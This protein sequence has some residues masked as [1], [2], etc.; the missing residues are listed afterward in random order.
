MGCCPGKL[1]SAVLEDKTL[2]P[3]LLDPPPRVQ[4]PFPMAG[5]SSVLILCPD[6]FQRD[7]KRSWTML[8]YL[9]FYFFNLELEVMH[10][11][12]SLFQKAAH[13]LNEV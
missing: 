2:L 9:F 10:S 13:S 8:G 6:F 12:A 11:N 4:K 1:H 3:A 5:S 7:A